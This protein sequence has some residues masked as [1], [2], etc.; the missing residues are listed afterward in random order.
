MVEHKMCTCYDILLVTFI[1]STPDIGKNTHF[2]HVIKKKL[3]TVDKCNEKIL[4]CPLFITYVLG[5]CCCRNNGFSKK[6]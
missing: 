4:L 3:K 1:L 6:A 5:N 2:M